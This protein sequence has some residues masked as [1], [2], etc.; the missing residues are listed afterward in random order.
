[1]KEGLLGFGMMRL[2]VKSGDPTDFDYEQLNKMVDAYLEAGYHYFDTSY[3]YHNG[4]SEEALRKAAVERYPRERLTIAT[5]FPSFAFE[6]EDQIE[7]IF[8]EQLRNL[9]VDYVDYY[10]VHNVQTVFYDGVDGK[11]GVVQKA[12]LFDHVKKW[13]EQGR[14]RHIGISFH[15]S[16]ALLERVL[17]EHPEIEFVQLAVNYV[18][19]ESEMVQARACYE[20]ARKHGKEVII[21]EPVKGGGLARLPEAAERV[22][23]ESCPDRSIVS[24]A[25]RFLASLEGVIT[26]LSGMSTLEQM[27]DNIRTMGSITPLSGSEQEA[28][29]RA[30]Q[31]YR[32]SAPIP[33]GVIEK[34][35]G[36]TYHGVSAS[37]I[38]QTYSICQIQPNPTF[39]CDIN[40]PM[41]CL[42]EGAHLDLRSADPFPEET[43]ILADGTDGT[44]LLKKAE[45]W[46]REHHF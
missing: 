42:A 28:L 20:T 33:T 14:A 11:G 38:L 45:A 41:N 19:W 10:L 1:M 39:S 21:M 36:L 25:F 32:D 8:E 40:Y 34:Y 2:P 29:S 30:V 5:K 9:G 26:V 3:V 22:L 46:L 31:I 16:P 44:P 27:E 13:K 12:H 37:A 35:K 7:P 23:K 43:V 18:D 17:I 6:R 4:K 15:S 24:W